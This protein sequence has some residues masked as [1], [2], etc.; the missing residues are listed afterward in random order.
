MINLII[1][2]LAKIKQV[3]YLNKLDHKPRNLPIEW[4]VVKP[5]VLIS[6]TKK[7]K[8]I[9]KEVLVYLNNINLILTNSNKLKIKREVQ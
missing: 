9:Q 6:W 4:K 3:V 8:K 1:W 5:L 7:N 2:W